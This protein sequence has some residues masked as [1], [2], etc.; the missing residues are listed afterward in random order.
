[1]AASPSSPARGQMDAGDVGRIGNA[2]SADHSV[3]LAGGGM[4][5]PDNSTAVLRV[6]AVNPSVAHTSE[7][8]ALL[9]GRDWSD[10]HA[11]GFTT[12][13]AT[14]RQDEAARLST[15]VSLPQAISTSL[16]TGPRGLLAS[17]TVLDWFFAR[18]NRGD[19]STGGDAGSED[20][21]PSTLDVAPDSQAAPAGTQREEQ[22]SAQPDQVMP[23]AVLPPAALDAVFAG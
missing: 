14:W 3:V 18:S 20:M 5:L 6:T 17:T 1:P 16:N 9:A 10:N 23:P 19:D 2:S 7:L 13:P 12:A 21:M 8:A 22:P 4:S 15:W 11:T